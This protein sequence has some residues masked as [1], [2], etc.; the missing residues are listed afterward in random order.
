MERFFNRIIKLLERN[1]DDGLASSYTYLIARDALERSGHHETNG[2]EDTLF[3]DYAA[4]VAGLGKA[5]PLSD[6]EVSTAQD[7]AK[8]LRGIHEKGAE[9]RYVEAMHGESLVGHRALGLA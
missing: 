8:F 5:H 9:E 7:L 6:E 3:R 2:T 4:I 1:P